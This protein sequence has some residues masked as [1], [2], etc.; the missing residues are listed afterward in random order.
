[1]EAV[2]NALH[3]WDGTVLKKPRG[4]LRSLSRQ[5]EEVLRAEMS[6]ENIPRQEEIMEEEEIYK[7]QRSRVNWRMHG[8]RNSAF[9]HNYEKARKNKNMIVKLKGGD[10]NW[11]EGNTL[12]KPLITEY[13]SSLFTLEVGETIRSCCS[14]SN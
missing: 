14:E 3:A 9:F 4:R 1:V 5:L 6:Q 12:I 2:N 8:D 11:R 7:I 13:F 10:G